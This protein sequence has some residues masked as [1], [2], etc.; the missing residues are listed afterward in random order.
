M[1]NRLSVALLLLLGAAACRNTPEK[2]PEE[3]EVAETRT[4]GTVKIL[5]DETFLPIVNDQIEVFQSDYPDAVIT[6]V[7]GYEN[8]I[9]PT[10]LNDSVRVVVLSRM[11]TPDEEKYYTRRRIKV[12]TS[13]FA[14]DGIALITHKGNKDS[15]ISVNDVKEILRGNQPTKQ[16]VFDNPYSSTL[17]YFR[18]LAGVKELPKKGV[19]TLQSN[20]DVIKYVASH[21]GTIGVVGVNWLSEKNS[22]AAAALSQVRMVGVR[23]EKDQM[24]YK[25]TQENLMNGMYP[26]LRNIYIIN[27][28]GREGLGTG[29][30]NWLL[31]QRGQIIVLKSGL[32]PHKLNP[33][34]INLTKS[35]N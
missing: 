35:T 12:G 4:S 32:G 21:P 23:S 7:P 34:T 1:M 25:P 30:A 29:F 20:N 31:S 28:E 24:Y 8:R 33:R 27:C 11:L 17:R 6:P 3:K 18:E 5:V 10:F 9:L 13:R 2:S 15:T 22:S 26:F 16:L 14:I 19:Y